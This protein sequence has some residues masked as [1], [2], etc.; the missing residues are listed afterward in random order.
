MYDAVKHFSLSGKVALVT[1]AARGLGAET[2]LAL[3]NAGAKVMLSDILVA[4]AQATAASIRAAGGEAQAV[5]HDVSSE[6]DWERAIDATIETFGGLDVLV[7]NAGIEKAALLTEA[8]LDD[9]RRL[10]E[11]NVGGVFL[12]LKHAARAMRPGGAAG[13]GGSIVNLS[14]VA[15]LVGVPTL[16][17]YCA[18]KGA[19]RL[20]SKAAAVEFAKLGYGIRVNTVHPGI[21]KTEMGVNVVRGLVA[22]GLAPDEASSDAYVQSMHPLGYGHPQDVAS[23]V[24]YLASEASRWSTGS[25][26]VI[27]GGLTAN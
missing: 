13:R 10:Y 17:G 6:A 18:S 19:V 7:N 14:S 26:I 24:L 5:H 27:D 25:E 1:G 2:A 9:F 21:V 3:A 20:I 23:A 16:S 8:S 22:A 11:I 15:G 4:D 12:G